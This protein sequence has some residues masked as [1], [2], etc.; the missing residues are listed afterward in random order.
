MEER[1]PVLDSFGNKV[2]DF[3]PTAVVGCGCIPVA[4]VVFGLLFYFVPIAMLVLPPILFGGAVLILAE[5]FVGRPLLALGGL[6][7]VEAALICG[8]LLPLEAQR[9]RVGR[10]RRG[11]GPRGRLPLPVGA[12][13][14]RAAR[15]WTSHQVAVAAAAKTKTTS[16]RS[17]IGHPA[18]RL[19]G[20]VPGGGD[21]E[22][23]GTCSRASQ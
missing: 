16:A 13:R 9:L 1:I 14:L 3:I 11:A 17:T 5:G 8:G 6:L 23:P 12:V 7:G 19:P 18:G 2:G 22:K 21:F 15:R 10:R 20:K 4:A